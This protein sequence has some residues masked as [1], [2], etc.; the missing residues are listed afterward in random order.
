MAL[1]DWIGTFIKPLDRLLIIHL[2]T[3]RCTILRDG[4]RRPEG[5]G[6]LEQ[7][8]YISALYIGLTKRQRGPRREFEEILVDAKWFRHITVAKL[9]RQDI[10][11]DVHGQTGQA[12]ERFQLGGKGDEAVL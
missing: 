12:M 1:P 10:S 8:G 2:E 3:V 7:R 11:V 5:F 4:S 9:K 6:L